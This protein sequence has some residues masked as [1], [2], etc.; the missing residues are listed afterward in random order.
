MSRIPL[1]HCMKALFYCAGL[2]CFTQTAFADTQQTPDEIQLTPE[3]VPVD[4]WQK[5]R[6]EV[7]LTDGE[8]ALRDIGTGDGGC[9]K[10]RCEAVEFP[11]SS[12]AR[13]R[14]PDLAAAATGFDPWLPH[15]QT[16]GSF[17]GLV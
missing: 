5:N 16:R 3:T 14:R 8:V 1:N 10:L 17:C 11:G 4:I 13:G 12:L 15:G 9:R 7:S 6:F 2:L